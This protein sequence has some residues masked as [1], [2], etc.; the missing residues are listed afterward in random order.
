MPSQTGYQLR[1]VVD[2]GVANSNRPI[3]VAR[4]QERGEVGCV[5]ADD[6]T[7]WRCRG[8]ELSAHESRQTRQ[9]ADSRYLRELHQR[10]VSE[11]NY[12]LTKQR[13][14]QPHRALNRDY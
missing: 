7:T 1:V 3:V 11:H 12:R 2:L 5:G 9:A 6:L 14:L 10:R 13:G 8:G 4:R